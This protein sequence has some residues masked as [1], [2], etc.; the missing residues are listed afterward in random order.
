MSVRI[1]LGINFVCGHHVRPQNI[2]QVSHRSWKPWKIMEFKSF[3]FQA[4]KFTE[5]NRRSW[6]VMENE[7]LQMTRQGQCKIERREK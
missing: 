5:F 4:W 1:V 7:S 3:I 6:K 2:V